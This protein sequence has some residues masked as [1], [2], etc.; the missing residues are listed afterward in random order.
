MMRDANKSLSAGY[1]KY[2]FGIL[3]A[4]TGLYVLFLAG[5]RVIGAYLSAQGSMM[6]QDGDPVEFLF[7]YLRVADSGLCSFLAA[8][9]MLLCC[10]VCLLAQKKLQAYIWH[11]FLFLTAPFPVMWGLSL[12]FSYKIEDYARPG[13]V[14]TNSQVWLCWVAGFVLLLVITIVSAA[15]K[16]KA[17]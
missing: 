7:D 14:I 8:G 3:Y 6:R 11:T 17:Q 13:F 4:F 16:R 9:Y 10:L 1:K 12:I 15:A 2:L 5:A